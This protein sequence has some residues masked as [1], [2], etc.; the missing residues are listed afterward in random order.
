LNL[1]TI[2]SELKAERARIDKAIGALEGISAKG[3]VGRSVSGER[4]AGSK[5]RGHLSAEGRK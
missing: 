4:I 1:V 2:I 5:K 3:V